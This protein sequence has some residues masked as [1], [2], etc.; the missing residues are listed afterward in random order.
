MQLV[1]V[2]MWYYDS[3]DRLHNY[4]Q[5]SFTRGKPAVVKT[6]QDNSSAE[7][8]VFRLEL[9]L[10]LFYLASEFNDVG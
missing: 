6:E 5:A 1:G 8:I 3:F 4:Q 2:A 9:V 7:V 10:L